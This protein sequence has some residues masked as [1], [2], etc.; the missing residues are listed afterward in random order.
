MTAKDVACLVRYCLAIRYQKG[1]DTVC[2]FYVPG[3]QTKP[4][5]FTCRQRSW[6]T[7]YEL[8]EMA[9]I[10]R[11]EAQFLQELYTIIQQGWPENQAGVPQSLI[12][13]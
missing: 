2:T 13:Y 9:T 5:T 6:P 10:K 3:E 11:E 12:S 1:K 4:R 8:W 7:P